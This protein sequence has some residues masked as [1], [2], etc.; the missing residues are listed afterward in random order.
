MQYRNIPVVI[1]AVKWTGH[2]HRDMF[3]FLGGSGLITPDGDNF[4]IS[5]TKVE[6]GLMI[7]T[8]V[9]E[10]TASIGDYIIKGISGGYYPC[11]AY[12]FDAT[13][14]GLDSE[15]NQKGDPCFHVN[16]VTGLK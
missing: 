12:I 4:Y 7:K 5:H 16:D 15:P 8:L 10:D 11:K 13:Y 2:N 6:G 14:T 3:E 1:E 9:G